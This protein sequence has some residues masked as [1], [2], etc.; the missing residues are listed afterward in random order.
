MIGV[1]LI[2]PNIA[3]SEENI[4]RHVEYIFT[5]QANLM[6]VTTITDKSI[7]N[8]NPF[9]HSY[10]SELWMNVFFSLDGSASPSQI[11]SITHHILLEIRK[12]M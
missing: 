9:H 12:L 4:F 6:E 8:F 3:V 5:W 7:M 2:P 1:A 10:S 11:I